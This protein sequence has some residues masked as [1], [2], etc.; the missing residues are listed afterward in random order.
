MLKYQQA[1]KYNETSRKKKNW[2]KSVDNKFSSEE[3]KSDS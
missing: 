2:A 1:N 3:F